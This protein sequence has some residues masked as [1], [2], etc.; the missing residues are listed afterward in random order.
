MKIKEI[1]TEGLYN[2]FNHH[3]PLNQKEG[4]TI[5]HS[6]NGF[7]KTTLLRMIDGLFNLNPSVFS[8]VPFKL[9]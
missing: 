2:T 8:G 4:I 7:G 5:I 1:I 3:I 6:P 9:N